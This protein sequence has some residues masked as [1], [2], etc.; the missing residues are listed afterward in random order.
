MTPIAFLKIFLPSL[1][2]GIW[3]LPLS[4]QVQSSWMHL[5][6]DVR[7]DTYRQGSPVIRYSESLKVPDLGEHPFL[8]HAVQIAGQPMEVALRTSPN[9]TEWSPF[10]LLESDPHSPDDAGF[11]SN[12][13]ELAGDAVFMQLKVSFETLPE[14]ALSPRWYVCNPGFGLPDNEK[15]GKSRS[16][17]LPCPRPVVKTRTAWCPSG[18]CFPDPTPV[19]TVPTHFIVHHSAGVNSSTD[20]AA[21]VRGIW[22][23]HVNV[24]GW[25]D[26]GYNWLI[27]PNG[28]IYEGR[29]DSLQGAH[30]CGNN[31]QTTGICMLGNFQ[32]TKPS[33]ESKRSLVELLA[34]KCGVEALDPLGIGFHVPSGLNLYVV[35]GHRDGCSTSCPGDQF[36]PLLPI[37]REAMD[38]YIEDDCY[39]ASEGEGPERHSFSLFPNPVTDRL[40]IQ[41]PVGSQVN[42]WRYAIYYMATGQVADLGQFVPVGGAIHLPMM[43]LQEASYLLVLEEENTGKTLRQQIIKVQ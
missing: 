29:A 13:Y 1:F 33:G 40:E 10:Q 26:I 17:S 34:W 15:T 7:Q 12:L 4:G 5:T 39:L 6:W 19:L 41:L 20:W 21:V 36:Y 16:D 8:L 42:T 9:G 43:R 30:F 31:S 25:D 14:A 3:I 27:D 24:N 18:N 35:S 2:L 32:A 38:M 11:F 22:D 28:V 37:I 23:Y